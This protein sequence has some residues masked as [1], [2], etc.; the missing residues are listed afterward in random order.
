MGPTRDRQAHTRLNRYHFFTI[1]LLPPHLSSTGKEKPDLLYRS[2]CD[3]LR[4][5]SRAEFK[6]GH[7]STLE[8]EQ[9]PYI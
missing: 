7:P 2:M 3:R 9:Y 1:I 6:V 4:Y 8:L 5:L